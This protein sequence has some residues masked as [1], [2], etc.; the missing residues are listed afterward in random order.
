MPTPLFTFRLDKASS[1]ELRKVAT[2]YNGGN[3]SAFLREI[4]T[5]YVSGEPAK[6]AAFNRELMGRMGEQLTLD[7]MAAAKTGRKKGGRRARRKTR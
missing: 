5:A 3:V 6:I 1:A 7:L 2:V 4:I